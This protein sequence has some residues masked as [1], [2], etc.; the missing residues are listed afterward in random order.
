MKSRSILPSESRESN[1]RVLPRRTRAA[2]R[3]HSKEGLAGIPRAPL[4][5]VRPRNRRR[6]RRNDRVAR[7]ELW[8]GTCDEG[9]RIGKARPRTASPIFFT[10]RTPYPNLRNHE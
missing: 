8:R 4:R 6:A 5:R 2:A 9:N 7:Q 10:S 1:F 3:S